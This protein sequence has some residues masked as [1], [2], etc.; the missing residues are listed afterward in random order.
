MEQYIRD[1]SNR[2]SARS[3]RASAESF[4]LYAKWAAILILALALAVLLIFPGLRIYKQPPEPKI[5][6]KEKVVVKNEPINIVVKTEKSN[7]SSFNNPSK[8]KSEI[9]RKIGVGKIVEN[10]VKFTRIPFNENGFNF[11]SIG[12]GFENENSPFPR[13]QWCYTNK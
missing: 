2:I 8:A 5:I 6:T 10:Y 3:K 4:G 1:R 13:K 12:R 11:V 9:E 7:Q